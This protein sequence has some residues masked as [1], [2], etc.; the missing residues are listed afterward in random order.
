MLGVSSQWRSVPIARALKALVRIQLQQAAEK[1]SLRGQALSLGAHTMHRQ[2]DANMPSTSSHCARHVP[3]SHASFIIEAGYY[4]VWGFSTPET[5]TPLQH[6]ATCLTTSQPGV[7]LDSSTRHHAP[8]AMGRSSYCSPYLVT[9]MK[10]NKDRA[11]CLQLLLPR[12]ST[13]A[14]DIHK[15][16]QTS[17]APIAV[18][19]HSGK[20]APAWAWLWVPDGPIVRPGPRPGSSYGT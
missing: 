1:L 14:Q 4:V 5:T 18:V 12:H 6:D 9:A 10:L 13:K 11:D 17:A 19:S 16:Q 7:S 2:T 15:L 20:P 8:V 3:I